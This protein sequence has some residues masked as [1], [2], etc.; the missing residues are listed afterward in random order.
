VHVSSI[1]V[2]YPTCRND[3]LQVT[4][5]PTGLKK[6]KGKGRKEK[7]GGGPLNWSKNLFLFPGCSV[8]VQKQELGKKKKKKKKKKHHFGRKK[9]ER[10][11]DKKKK[12]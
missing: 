3:R 9:R 10:G 1:R 8:E 6:K 7:E 5:S 2:Y 4:G 11:R 12:R